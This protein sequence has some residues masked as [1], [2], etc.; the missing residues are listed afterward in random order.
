M[1]AVAAS[2]VETPLVFEAFQ[3][4]LHQALDDTDTQPPVAN[5]ELSWRTFVLVVV[6]YF[7]AGLQSGRLL[8]THLQ[9]APAELNLPT[10]LKKSTFFEGFRRFTPEQ[11]RQLFHALL[12]SLSFFPV[13]EMAT[14]G[15]LCAVDGS[16]WP[17]LF[18]M[19]WALSGPHKPTVLVHLAF[20]LNQMLPVSMLLTESNSSERKALLQ[21]LQAGITYVADR[22]YFAYYLLL[23][24]ANAGAFFV[25]RAPCSVTYEILEVLPVTLPSAV[26]WLVQVHDLKVFCDKKEHSGIWRVVRFSIGQT[27]FILF[28]NRWELTTWQIITI[29]AYRWQIE[30]LFLFVKR[31]L[32]GLHLLSHSRRGLEIQFYLMLATALLLLYF[33]QRNEQAAGAECPAGQAVPILWAE[34][35]DDG[36]AEGTP[37]SSTAEPAAEPA[38]TPTSQACEATPVR[39][40]EEERPAAPPPNQDR[41]APLPA[42]QQPQPTP[43]QDSQTAA[44]SQTRPEK[45]CQQGRV[46][47]KANAKWYRHLGKNL[48]R[49]WRISRH[50]LE[51]LRQNLARA[52]DP[53]VFRI[54]PGASSP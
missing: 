28:S 2:E 39:Q 44:A 18:S 43:S 37:T 22:G 40:A 41:A 19:R 1:Y 17:A 12:S 4:P 49:F 27:E 54:V 30:L 26:T 20:G 36:N 51:V 29:Y 50:W 24:I 48:S 21:M 38:Q 8:L 16:H 52:W 14:L 23:D 7:V 25:I 47:G 15:L 31:T 45:P 33:K 34:T 9:H 32:N 5:E 10:D 11:A 13:A 3:E 46:H 42:K 6:Y 35:A 53:A